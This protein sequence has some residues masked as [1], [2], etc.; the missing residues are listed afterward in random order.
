MKTD[1]SKHG[2]VVDKYFF[3]LC[4]HTLLALEVL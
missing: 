4:V 2:L 1:R 3:K